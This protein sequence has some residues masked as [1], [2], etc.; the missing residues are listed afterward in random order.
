MPRPQQRGF[1]LGLF[2]LTNTTPSLV[3]PWMVVLI[4][5]VFGYS[6]LFAALALC[7]VAAAALLATIR[8]QT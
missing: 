4:E 2:N 6:G 3:M 7:A 5:P 8:R 1:H